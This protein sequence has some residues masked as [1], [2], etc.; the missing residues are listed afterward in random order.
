MNIAS[1]SNPNMCLGCDQVLADDSPMVATKEESSVPFASD[2][3]PVLVANATAETH[4]SGYPM[5]V[6]G[7]RTITRSKTVGRKRNAENTKR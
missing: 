5:S 4:K 2:D 7:P 3:E 1:P 6:E